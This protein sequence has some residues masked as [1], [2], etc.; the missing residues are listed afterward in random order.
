ML[1]S[2]VANRARSMTEF[3]AVK[4]PRVL[5]DRYWIW[6]SALDMI[7]DRPLLGWGYGSK[8]FQRA[9]PSYIQPSALGEVYENAHSFYLQ[10]AVELGIIG[11]PVV[12]S[13]IGLVIVRGLR[14]IAR[15]TRTVPLAYLRGMTAGMVVFLVYGFTTYRFE[16]ETGFLIWYLLASLSAI[17]MDNRG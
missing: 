6:M 14:A 10:E 11:L 15:Q 12:L 9:Y 7:R 5:G 3:E 13:F 1:P 4:T 8:S 2:Q 16:N 17:S